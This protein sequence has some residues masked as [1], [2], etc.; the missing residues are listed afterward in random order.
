MLADFQRHLDQTQLMPAGS[1]VL[2]GFS[3]GA[4]SNCLLHLMALLKFDIIAAHLHHGQRPEADADL[5]HCQAVCDELGVPFVSGRADV[6]LLAK[7]RKI[8][9]EEAGRIAR[10]GFFEQAA[11]QTGCTTIATAHTKTD[12]AETVL[13]HLIRGSGLTGVAGFGNR[14]GNIIRPLRPFS[15]EQTIAYC[16]EHGLKFLED[17]ANTDLRH[18]RSRIRNQISPELRQIQPDFESAIL[19]FSDIA[20]EEDRLL[21]SYAVALLQHAAVALNG[22]LGFLTADCEVALDAQ[23]LGRAQ[24]PLVRRGIRLIALQLGAEPEHAHIEQTLELLRTGSKD[25]VTFPGGD[26]VAEIDDSAVHIRQLRAVMPFRELLTVPGETES[27]E[28][29]WRFEAVFCRV[30][31]SAARASLTAHLDPGKIKGN[32]YF[33]TA[34]LG[35]KIDPLGFNG[36][37]KLSDLLGEAKLTLAG[38]KRLPILCDM[39][40]PV[41]VPG[42]CQSNRVQYV[43]DSA[44]C[45][46]IRFGPVMRHS[47][48]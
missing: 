44:D 4:D 2:L 46:Q 39:A 22:D 11:L 42:I 47:L 15:R 14:R 16:H 29:G 43:G 30:Q 12:L 27:T 19:R 23:V 38:R 45:L 21:D 35:D 40:G 13:F 26:V 24:A 7:E 1:R 10:Y 33:R 3:G 5:A 48:G 17:P 6:P 25:S 34:E 8:G 20:S 36:T 32:L 37:R 18:S 41:W 31:E 28:F 9:L